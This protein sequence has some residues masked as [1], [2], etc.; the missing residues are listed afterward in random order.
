MIN[1]SFSRIRQPVKREGA[2]RYLLFT[3]LSFAASVSLT[4]LFL[5]AT[6]FPQVGGGELHIAHVLWGGLLLFIAALVP[7]ILA[8]RW[9]YTLSA[10][11]TGAGVGLF[12]DE[13]GKFIT[14]NNDYFY[15]AAAP[16]IYVFFLLTVLLYLE[17]RR[18]PSMDA[19]TELYCVFDDLQ[20]VID[21]DLDP[22]E[23]AGMEERLRNIAGQADSPDLA[24]LANEL[25]HFLAADSLYLVPRVPSVWE[26]WM[27]RLWALQMRWLKQY[28]LKAILA[29]G[30]AAL[31]VLALADLAQLL[32]AVRSPELLH[33]VLANMI[34]E[35]RIASASGLG[36][37]YANLALQGAVGL[38]L[39]IAAGLLASGRERQGIRLGYLGL[40]LSLTAVDLLMFYFDQFSAILPALVQFGLLL[41]VLFYRRRYLTK[42][43]E[44]RQSVTKGSAHGSSVAER[45]RA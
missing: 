35:S 4:R 22:Q 6:G 3:L 9:A 33:R 24:R 27:G 15:P 39:L 34:A 43:E 12:I 28:R 32:W 14:R 36:W 21:R 37:L 5:W 25:L 45:Y 20:E 26:R 44:N 2:E 10:I 17:V 29:G 19:R 11:L 16:I 18:P 38:L 23:R 42:Y 1:R 40:L 13:V 8:N 41:G 7:L 31:G 30:L